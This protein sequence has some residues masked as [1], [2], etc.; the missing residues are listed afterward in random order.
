[1][2]VNRPF[3]HPRGDG[4]VIETAVLGK[5][6]GPIPGGVLSGRWVSH[7]RIFGLGRSSPVMHPRLRVVCPGAGFALAGIVVGH[8]CAAADARPEAVGR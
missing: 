7:P 5:K 1:V 3:D 6:P 8:G 2:A 4:L